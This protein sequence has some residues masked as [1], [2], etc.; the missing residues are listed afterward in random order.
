[1][2]QELSSWKPQEEVKRFLAGLPL[3][4]RSSHLSSQGCLGWRWKSC[5]SSAFSTSKNCIS[6]VSHRRH[7]L[8]PEL[9]HPG[10][11]PSSQRLGDDQEA[12][13]RTLRMVAPTSGRQCGQI[14]EGA[15]LA[16]ACSRGP[17]SLSVLVT[18]GGYHVSTALLT[19]RAPARWPPRHSHLIEP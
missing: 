11:P 13:G 3:H 16:P 9:L 1:M 6:L 8:A 4:P 18:W 19:R 2:R 10:N 12:P 14:P 17:S 15:P 7:C 5:S